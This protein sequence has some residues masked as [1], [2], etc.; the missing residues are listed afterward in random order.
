MKLKDVLIIGVLAASISA[1]IIGFR[2]LDATTTMIDVIHI[3]K[4][5]LSIVGRNE[6][7]NQTLDALIAQPPI[8]VGDYYDLVAIYES[9]MTK[10]KTEILDKG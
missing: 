10:H 7:Y 1:A 2:S 9:E 6:L 8:S 3:Q 5:R 4:E